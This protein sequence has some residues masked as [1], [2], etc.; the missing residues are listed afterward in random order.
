MEPRTFLISS[1]IGDEVGLARDEP[2]LPIRTFAALI[3]FQFDETADGNMVN[4]TGVYLQFSNTPLETERYTILDATLEETFIT[5]RLLEMP[6]DKLDQIYFARPVDL[7]HGG[8]ME[9]DLHIR[10]AN[11]SIVEVPAEFFT[12]EKIGEMLI[13]H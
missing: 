7:L 3:Q 6:K 5:F 11:G 13:E 4:G 9:D 10:R 8:I 2:Q 1:I 12:P